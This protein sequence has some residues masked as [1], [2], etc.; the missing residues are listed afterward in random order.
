[1]VVKVRIGRA[2]AWGLVVG[3]LSLGG[4][5]FAQTS[6]LEL[7]AIDS[8]ANPCNDFYQYACGNWIKNNPIPADESTWGRFDEL[9]QRNQMLLRGL[10]EDSAKNQGRSAIDQQIGGFYQSC[11][12][13]GAIEKLGTT[14]LQAELERIAH[15]TNRQELLEEVARLHR[16]QVGVFF[17]FDST[18]DPKNAALT[19]AEID[20]GGLGLPERDFYFRSDAKSEEIRKKY[21]VHIAKMLELIGVP[22]DEA[23]KKAAAIMAIETELAKA[24]LDVTSRR[25]PQK[26][27]HELP[28]AE[29]KKLSPVIN[30]NQFFVAVKAPEFSM[31][32]VAVPDFFKGLN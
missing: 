31:L 29:L 22:A 5:A 17:T 16:R 15:I 14:P 27:V 1:M 30:F 28:T 26:L 10:L 23:A 20:Q 8:T 25:D 2:I 13:D 6:G 11:M 12:D 7:S 21:V 24:S 32:N 18:P 9:F 4:A 3:G 19:I